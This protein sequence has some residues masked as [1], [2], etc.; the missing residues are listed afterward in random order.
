MQKLSCSYFVNIWIYNRVL[1]NKYFTLKLE[2]VKFYDSV[3]LLHFVE[4][5]IYKS[6][7]LQKK[8]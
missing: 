1:F 3:Y 2:L 4:I 7:K 5:C 8:M 6:E